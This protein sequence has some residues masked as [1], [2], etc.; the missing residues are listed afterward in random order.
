MSEKNKMLDNTEYICN[1][2]EC[3]F[4]LNCSYCT[5][6][7]N[8]LKRIKKAKMIKDVLVVVDMQNDFV[9]GSLGSKQ[10]AAIVPSVVDKIRNFDGLV[11]FTKDIHNSDKYLQT[12]EGKN[13]PVLHCAT[14]WGADFVDE[15]DYLLSELKEYQVVFKETFG[16]MNLFYS[17]TKNLGK[18]QLGTIEICGL[19]SSICVI[20]NAVLLTTAFP[21][22]DI[23]VDSKCVAGVEDKDNQAALLVMEKLQIKVI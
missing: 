1:E 8:K 7:K 10:A 16:T 15:I 22:T 17:I 3:D 20:S 9:T 13:L 21:E 19:V 12:K 2:L 23:I 5:Q 11:I 4:P 6:Y 14:A 18:Y